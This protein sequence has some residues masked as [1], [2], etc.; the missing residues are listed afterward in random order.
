MVAILNI[1]DLRSIME[2]MLR[3][4]SLSIYVPFLGKKRTSLYIFLEKGNHYYIQTWHNIFLGKR[5]EKL[6]QKV[7]VKTE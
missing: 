5:K 1:L 6:A 7:C 4:H 3:G 2:W